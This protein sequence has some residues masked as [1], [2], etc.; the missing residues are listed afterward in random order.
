V[1][2]RLGIARRDIPVDYRNFK[3]QYY[4]KIN[5]TIER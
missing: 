4:T 1:R 2:F 3:E 5:N